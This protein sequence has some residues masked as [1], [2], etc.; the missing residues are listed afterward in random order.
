LIF[1]YLKNI[2]ED[3]LSIG[4]PEEEGLVKVNTQELSAEELLNEV[5][6]AITNLK[7][8]VKG[9]QKINLRNEGNENVILDKHLFQT[10][11]YKPYSKC[12]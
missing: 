1:L 2:L 7:L 9:G 6:N 5:S 12:N 4:K 3:F 8:S 10:H 11:Y